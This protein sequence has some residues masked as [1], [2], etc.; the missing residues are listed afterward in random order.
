MRLFRTA[1]LRLITTAVVFSALLVSSVE[2]AGCEDDGASRPDQ[3]TE[4]VATPPA[5]DVG[6]GHESLHCCPCVH[7]F[8][9][10]PALVMTAGT[11]LTPADRM[12][13]APAVAVRSA[14][15][16]PPLRPPIA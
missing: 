9:T 3:A 5:Q 15:F 16:A 2:A 4:L 10:A 8:A 12:P 1:A 6:T 13:T 11:V 7:V 14:S